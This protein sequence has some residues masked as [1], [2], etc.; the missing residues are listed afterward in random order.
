MEWVE[1]ETDLEKY[2]GRRG[3]LSLVGMGVGIEVSYLGKYIVRDFQEGVP[4]SYLPGP[5]ESDGHHA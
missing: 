3:S 5:S 2:K 4:F 1:L